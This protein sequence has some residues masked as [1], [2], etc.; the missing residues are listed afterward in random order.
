MEPAP[1]HTFGWIYILFN[2]DNWE[3]CK[4]GQTIKEKLTSR[5]RQTGNPSALL[6]KA[7]RIPVSSDEELE[8]IEKFIHHHMSARIHHASTGNPSEWFRCTPQNADGMV[9]QYIEKCISVWRTD[10][11][12]M[13][14]NILDSYSYVEPYPY[15]FF[16][17]LIDK[18]LWPAW[19]ERFPQWPLHQ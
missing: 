10:L 3:V 8:R 9:R 15:H 14:I 17:H 6:Y 2:Y 4:I 19:T 7:Y 16:Y 11:Q 1:I 12:G 13:E 5:V 18:E